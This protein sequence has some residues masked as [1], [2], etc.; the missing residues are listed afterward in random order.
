[1]EIPGRCFAASWSSCHMHCGNLPTVSAALP[2][3]LKPRKITDFCDEGFS[4]MI[5]NTFYFVRLEFSFA[6]VFEMD[7]ESFVKLDP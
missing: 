4:V 7:F 3:S 6:K 5:R 1:M 2:C